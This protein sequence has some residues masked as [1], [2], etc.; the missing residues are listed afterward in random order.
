MSLLRV[1]LLVSFLLG[2]RVLPFDYKIIVAVFLIFNC[3]AVGA[4]TPNGSLALQNMN[5]E[6]NQKPWQTYQ[7]LLSQTEQLAEATPEHKLWW[8]LRKAQAEVLLDLSDEFQ[9]TVIKAKKLI[10]EKTHSRIVINFNTFQG[11]IF[12]RQ[13]K[14]QQ[15]QQVLKDAQQQAIAH[16]YTD[17]A[18]NAKLELAFTRSLTELYEYSLTGLQQAY[19]EAFALNDKYLVAKINEVY[20][21]IYGYLHNYEKSIEYYQKA[22]TSYQQLAYPAREAEALYGLAVTYRYWQ[23]Y[24][25]ALY[26][27]H[28]YQKAIEFSP[29]NIEGQFYAIYGIAM[30]LSGKGDCPQALRTIK[31][32][33]NLPGLIDYKAE[34]YKR[35]AI[36]FI[37][38][39]Q[40]TL[41]A[42][43]LN[44]AEAIFTDIPELV[45]T[46]WQVEV[47]EIRA[48]LLQVKG[49]NEEAYLLLKQF[50]KRKV[51]Q[52]EKSA[53]DRLVRV[54]AALEVERKNVENA[55]LQQRNEVQK[56]RL[57][58][59]KQDNVI[60]QYTWTGVTIF[61]LF[62]M[63]VMYLQWRHRQKLLAMS[64]L[65]PLTGVYN[66]GY[67][68]NFLKKLVINSDFD[69]SQISVMLIDI[70]G[71]KRVNERY[72]YS[73]GDK[74]ISD[75]AHI[76]IETIRTEDVLGRVNGEQF[77]CVLPKIDSSQCLHIAQRLVR[78]IHEHEFFIGG[79][80]HKQ[81]VKITAS[82]GMSTTSLDFVN[83]LDL[84][85]EADK[86]LCHAKMSGKN[87]AVQYQKMM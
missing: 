70:D 86:A 10:N 1:N 83:S 48:Q 73:F 8:L 20:G 28:R 9:Q 81:Q 24:D 55:L 65:D 26:Y 37:R 79:G 18:V 52:L 87:R 67:I 21:D 53:A 60:H 84:Y 74:V 13:G 71:F 33:L 2:Y 17:L 27:Y 19:V 56:L 75:I 11:V 14:Y 61:F 64:T 46:R 32:A 7:K 39:R 59:Q 85:V 38:T 3:F 42:A 31:Q 58:Q 47:I 25:L 22:L 44:N 50:N 4:I 30:S 36:C 51:A 15:A 62:A 41:A 29:N 66:R 82:I 12:Q 40:L 45:G 16:K 77:L 72:G 69:K 57:A 34:L 49:D 43:A 68:F 23:K 6:L 54:R 78:K 76:S 63:V 35:Q 5:H 80:N